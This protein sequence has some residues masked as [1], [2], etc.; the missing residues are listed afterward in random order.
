M[1]KSSSQ[2]QSNESL[3]VLI[4]QPITESQPQSEYQGE[5]QLSTQDLSY[6][7]D[8]IWTKKKPTERDNEATA[9]M[10]KLREERSSLFDDK[11]TRKV[12]LWN[13]IAKD[14]K[15]KDFHLGE[16]GGERCRQKFANLQKAYLAYIK[17]QTTTGTERNDDFPPFFEE[18][19]SI[20]GY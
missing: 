3:E 4:G 14:L 2:T 16:K 17:H 5:S 7:K 12:K 9:L 19:H 11:K 18:L 1:L 6:T 20:L 10:L 15:E 8:T 13:D